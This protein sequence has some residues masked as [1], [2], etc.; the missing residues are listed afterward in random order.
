M[1]FCQEFGH[2]ARE[3]PHEVIC[4]SCQEAGHI[5]RDCP[6]EQGNGRGN[7]RGNFR[8]GHRG[9]YREGTRGHSHG[10]DV[11]VNL[12]STMGQPQVETREMGVQYEDGGEQV[13]LIA[14]G[15]WTFGEHPIVEAVSA[16]KGTPAVCI[17]PLQYVN[18]TVSGCDCVALED[19]GCQIPLIS[20]RLVSWCC[21]ETVGTVTLNGFGKNHTVQAPLVNM[22]VCLRDAERDDVCENPIVCAVTDLRAAE[23]DVILP[24]DVVRELRAT[25]IAVNVSGCDV[26]AVGDVGTETNDPEVE[27]NAPEDVD[28]LPVGEVKAN[29][30]AFVLEQEQDPS[31]ANCWM[32]AQA[33]E[34]GLNTNK[35]LLYHKDQAEGQ[36]VCQLCVP[37]GRRAKIWRL[38]HESVFEHVQSCRNCQ[39]RSRTVTTDRVPSTPITRADVAFQSMNMD[40]IG[41]SITAEAVDDIHEC[42]ATHDTKGGF[43]RFVIPN[44]ACVSV[45]V[46]SPECES[47]RIDHR[48]PEQRRD[49]LRGLNDVADQFVDSPG[50]CDAAVHRTTTTAA[51]VPRP[52]RPY[53]VKPEVDSQSQELRDRDLSRPSDNLMANP[54][55]CVAN[56]DGGGRIAC[57][58][59]DRNLIDS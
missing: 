52:M 59:R 4:Y 11:Y 38:A 31:L 27:Y 29:T 42:S 56:E 21:N 3:C 37:H 28:S 20:K 7:Y 2:I 51:F 58:Y 8:R 9:S 10:E 43:G 44:P 26:N 49:R 6:H 39:L 32:Q 16:V 22:T 13:N 15:N 55:V 12:V 57:D 33:G 41:P 53:H 50:P 1:L 45:V 54:I 25:S 35:S 34:G 48:A 5:A 40:C 19:S 14:T 47:V 17:Y 36:T 18:V 23:Y 30:T 24:A 46:F